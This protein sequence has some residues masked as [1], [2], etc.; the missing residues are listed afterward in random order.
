MEYQDTASSLE[1]MFTFT[2]AELT[3]IRQALAGDLYNKEEPRTTRQVK[4]ANLLTALCPVFGLSPLRLKFDLLADKPGAGTYLPADKVIIIGKRYSL[5]TLFHYFFMA[6]LDA[7][8]DDAAFVSMIRNSGKDL[9]TIMLGFAYS[10]FREASPERFEEAKRSGLLVH[11]KAR[12]QAGHTTTR[13]APEPE[14]EFEEEAEPSPGSMRPD[15]DPENRID[16]GN[17]LGE[18]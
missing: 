5:V 1:R 10:L 7:K 12:E 15:I 9:N 16:R 2:E 18:D 4:W 8:K 6:I 3:P 14:Q 17:G 11:L 13:R